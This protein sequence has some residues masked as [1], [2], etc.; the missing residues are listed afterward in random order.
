MTVPL[1]GLRVALAHAR[2]GDPD[3]IVVSHDGTATIVDGAR[4]DARLEGLA[5]ERALLRASHGGPAHRVLLAASDGNHS[6]A[7]LGVTRREVVIDG[8]RFEVDVEPAARA[9]LR[10]RATRDR[11]ASGHSGPANVRA[12]IPGV[13]VSVSVTPGDTVTA[14]QQLLVVEAMKMQNELRAPR[15]GTIEHVAVGAGATIDVGDVL[16]VIA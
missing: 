1:T 5:G 13:V 3:P 12:I 8:W 6:G 15:A 2:P 10:E 14:G 4:T 16:L 7:P 9:E 11:A